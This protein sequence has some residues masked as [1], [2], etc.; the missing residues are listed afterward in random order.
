MEHLVAG[1]RIGSWMVA[2]QS[3]VDHS[4]AAFGPVSRLAVSH[5]M[6]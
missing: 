1:T 6:K 5:E 4:G 3:A 2:G